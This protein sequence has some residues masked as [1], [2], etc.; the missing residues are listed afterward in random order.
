MAIGGWDWDGLKSVRLISFS[1][2]TI[3]GGCTTMDGIGIGIG[4]AGWGANNIFH[5]LGEI[6]HL[7]WCMHACLNI[8]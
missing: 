8:R 7:N 5:W 4:I 6:S 2:Y 1:K 3:R